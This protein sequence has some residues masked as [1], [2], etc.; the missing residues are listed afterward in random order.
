MAI[1]IHIVTVAFLPTKADGT[2]VLKNSPST[3]INDVKNT[4]HQHLVIPSSDVPS[5]A[6]YPTVDTYLKLEAAGDFVLKYMDQ[7]KIITYSQSDIN[8]A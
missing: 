4:S 1:R 3:T 8:A 2:V 6:G 5:S 7:N